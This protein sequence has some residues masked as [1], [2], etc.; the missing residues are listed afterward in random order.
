MRVVEDETVTGKNKSGIVYW[1]VLF[2]WLCESVAM[3]TAGP[4]DADSQARLAGQFDSGDGFFHVLS[5]A[6]DS[7]LEDRARLRLVLCQL[8]TFPPN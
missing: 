3:G 7:T 1:E 8:D 4:I 2:V 6:C 5:S